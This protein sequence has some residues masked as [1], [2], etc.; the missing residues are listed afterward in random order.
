M[1]AH[2]FHSA[3]GLVSISGSWSVEVEPERERMVL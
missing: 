3:N 2:N 1:S